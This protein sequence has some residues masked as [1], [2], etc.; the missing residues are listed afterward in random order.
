MLKT[1]DDFIPAVLDRVKKEYLCRMYKMTNW[2]NAHDFLEQVSRK[3]GKLLKHGEPDINAVAKMILNDWQ[4]GKLP[5]FVSPPV[6]PGKASEKTE[7]SETVEKAATEV[8]DEVSTAEESKKKKFEPKLLQDFSKI[9]VDLHYE[10]DD[11]QPLEPQELT[12]DAS[13][14][15]DDENEEEAAAGSVSVEPEPKTLPVETN[16]VADGSDD[17]EDFED[18]NEEDDEEESDDGVAKDKQ[19]K[20][21]SRTITKSGT[22]VVTPK[23]QSGKS[24]KR[25]NEDDDEDEGRNP[26]HKLTSKERRRIDRDQK[27]KKI[28]THFYDVVNVKNKSK[29]KGFLEM[30][31][32][33]R[34]HSKK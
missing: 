3:T 17:D 23:N 26:R 11:I 16:E 4:R 6:A 15:E 32:A 34:G 30:A 19:L 10:G 20:L 29:K 28:G 14:V 13:D 12:A 21:K 22:F 8:T 18:L 1:P 9:R 25:K 27:K 33:F 5:F 7:A 2:T 31:K 24:L